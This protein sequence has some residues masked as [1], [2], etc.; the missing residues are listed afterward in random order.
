MT[1]GRATVG[2][3]APTNYVWDREDGLPLLVGDGTNAYLHEDG[4]LAQINGA[5][6]PEY[7]LDDALG[8]RRG[9]TDLAGTLT[10][11]A[12]YDAFGAVR[13]SS[14]TGSVFAFTG[15]QFD[16]E[17]GYTYLRARYLNPTVGR[18]TSADSAQPN[19]PG[20]QGYNLYA[21][22]A[23]NPTAWVDPSGHEV[24]VNAAYLTGALLAGAFTMQGLMA[25]CGQQAQAAGAGTPAA[26]LAFGV[27]DLS[28]FIGIVVPVLLCALSTS[29]TVNP[30]GTMSVGN[31]CM[32]R[33]KD[34]AKVLGKVEPIPLPWP[35][36]PP[37]VIPCLVTPP[38]F[39]DLGWFMLHV[40]SGHSKSTAPEGAGVFSTYNSIEAY[41]DTVIA[42]NFLG[43]GR[44]VPDKGDCRAHIPFPGIGEERRGGKASDCL[45]VVVKGQLP[46]WYV[47]SAYPVANR[48]CGLP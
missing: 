3:G 14:G 38:V 32:D 17:T 35:K 42:A 46:P 25:I 33:A 26:G 43:A 9:V 10:G 45:R 1:T 2:G 30:D 44:W 4:A 21:Y 37:P 47:V 36:D 41:L 24:K 48:K 13:V 19:A 15:E 40:W 39:L 27:C 11:T 6:T 5:G 12:D 31:W 23:N 20:T 29:L 7:L 18:F 34:I 28:I 16:A 22:V 8:S